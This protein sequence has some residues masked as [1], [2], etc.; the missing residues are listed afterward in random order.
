MKCTCFARTLCAG[1]ELLRSGRVGMAT[2]LLQ[3]ALEEAEK[4]EATKT[5]P[6]VRP[7]SSPREQRTRRA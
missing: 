4:V 7:V 5:T 2:L 6:V 3:Q 1:L